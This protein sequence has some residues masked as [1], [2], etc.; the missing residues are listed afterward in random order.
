M[1]KN[2]NKKYSM[3]FRELLQLFPSGKQQGIAIFGLNFCYLAA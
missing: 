1:Q 2:E 3:S